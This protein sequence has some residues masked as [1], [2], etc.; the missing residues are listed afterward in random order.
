MN[1]SV[2]NRDVAEGQTLYPEPL[3]Y[4][5]P[6]WY[7]VYTFPRHEKTVQEQLLLRSVPSYLPL[8]E[9]RSRWKDRMVRLQLP[10]FPGYVFVRI[11]LRQRLR[12]LE[13]PGVVRLVGFNGHPAVLQDDEIESLQR[14]LAVRNAVPFPYLATGKRVHIK[15]GPLQGLQGVVVRRKGKLRI[16]VS[17]DSILRSISLEIEAADLQ[18]A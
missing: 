10:L 11:P 3:E 5:E 6:H 14:S 2:G 13:I 16:V 7:A 9:S 8:Y 15:S 18:A 17:V 12:V 1:A 4:R